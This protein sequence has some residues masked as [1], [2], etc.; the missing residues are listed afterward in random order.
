MLQTKAD[1]SSSKSRMNFL[2]T[3]VILVV[4]S[5]YYFSNHVVP[6]TFQY[7]EDRMILTGPSGAPF[8]V[9]LK[10]EEI[11]S[12]SEITELETGTNLSGINTEQCWFGTWENDCYGTYTLCASPSFS[13]YI[14]LETADG[15]V[16]CNYESADAT[17]H[18]YTALLEL[19]EA[20]GWSESLS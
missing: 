12:V 20:K 2:F 3:I 11:L 19:L 13:D 18:M 15:V 8:S 1:R 10:Y 17:Q 9:E 7:E 6:V 14:V 5:F 16:V 4:F